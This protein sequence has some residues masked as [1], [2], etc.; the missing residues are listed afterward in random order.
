MEALFALV[1]VALAAYVAA[2]L[3]R[4]PQLPAA[5][6]T[7]LRARRDALLGELRELEWDLSSGLIDHEGYEARRSEVEAQAADAWRA[8]DAQT[9]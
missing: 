7:E 5:E 4:T 3:Y 9:D 6:T 1:L 8:M 2:P